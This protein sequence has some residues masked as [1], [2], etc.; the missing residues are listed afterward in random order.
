MSVKWHATSLPV[1]DETV[2]LSSIYLRDQCTCSRCVD[3]SSKQKNFLTSEIPFDI[4]GEVI[5]SEEGVFTI[6]WTNDIKGFGPDHVTTFKETSL[7]D[8]SARDD[9]T[10]GSQPIEWTAEQ[11]E[12]DCKDVP[13]DEYMES[14]AV[15]QMILAQLRRYGLAFLTGVPEAEDSVSRI[16]ERI[17]P[18]KNTLYGYTW[19]VRSV[20]EATNVAYTSRDLGFHMDLLPMGYTPQFQFLHCLRSSAKG[21][22]SQFT[23]AFTAAQRL[24]REAPQKYLDLCDT[25]VTF[26][27]DHPETHLYRKIVPVLSTPF[28]ERGS[29]RLNEFGT[30]IPVTNIRWS[31]PFQGP[32]V[33]NSRPSKI[34]DSS[35]R[36]NFGIKL[37]RWRAAA[38]RFNSIIHRP[39]NIHERL[40]KPGECVIF[41][42][43][44]VLHARTAFEVDDAGK[45]RWLRGCYVDADV[46]KS[47]EKVLGRK[48]G[49]GNLS[50]LSPPV[51]N[52]SAKGFVDSSL[53]PS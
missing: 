18:V 15:L 30:T 39:L 14:D 46:F 33:F 48:I 29:D 41:N 22:L 51:R 16:A 40:M 2:E 6:R 28:K 53:L 19:D 38:D 25:Q 13:F 9:R 50:G 11:F 45:E 20:P 34:P 23:D 35:L 47:K 52:V 7:D 17:G 43:T 42:N 32:F 3:P 5:A 12:A 31:P 27:Y 10:P 4:Q 21:G 49:Y 24:W 26:H 36:H 1:G 44:R 37:A 8:L